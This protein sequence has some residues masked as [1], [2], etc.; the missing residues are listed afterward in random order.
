MK[1][2]PINPNNPH[3]PG[4]KKSSKYKGVSKHKVTGKWQATIRIEG[5]KIALG[6]YSNQT[7]AALAYNTAQRLANRPGFENTI[8]RGTKGIDQNDI[9]ARLHAYGLPVPADSQPGLR[10]SSE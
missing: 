7:Q 2:R 5:K 4:H 10:N 3:H 8:P 6:L 1:N 9:A